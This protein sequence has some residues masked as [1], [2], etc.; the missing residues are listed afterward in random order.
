MKKSNIKLTTSQFAQLHH[1][2]KRTLHYYDNIGLFSPN[3]KG[4]N[5]YRYYDLDQSITFEYILMLK[6]LGLSIHEIEEYIQR[7]TEEKFIHLAATKEIELDQQIKKLKLI[8]K[9]I[10]EKKKQI[11]R[12]Q[13]LAASTLE[14]IACEEEE[15]LFLPYDFDDEDLSNSFFYMTKA[16]DIDQIRMGVGGMISVEKVLQNDFSK[17]DGIYTPALHP[18]GE[19]NMHIKPKGTYLTYYHRGEWDTLPEAYQQII[20]YAKENQLKMTGY[21]YEIG[22]NEF[23]LSKEEDY[24]TKIAIRVEISGF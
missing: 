7:P 10:H 15:L 12:C 11:E 22:M 6:E 4:E 1:V 23:A 24:V 13:L 18:I 16:W 21:A 3:M 2:N 19:K 9:T 8:K 20:A 5:G 14:I 17:Y